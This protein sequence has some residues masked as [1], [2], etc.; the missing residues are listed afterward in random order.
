MARKKNVVTYRDEV[1]TLMRDLEFVDYPP[2]STFRVW[3]GDVPDYFGTHWHSAVEI[4]IP[5]EGSCTV[6]YDKAQYHVKAGEVL[7]TPSGEKHDLK[8]SPH[9]K[10]YIFL[11]EMES[12][13][14]IR[15][16]SAIKSMM[17]LPIH[18]TEDSP[19][20]SQVRDLLM[21]VIREYSS[22][23]PLRE[24]SCYAYILM[25]YALIGRD[26]LASAY[27]QANIQSG[28]HPAYLSVFHHVLYYIDHHFMED[29]SLESVAAEAGF[30]KYHFSRLFK[31]YTNVTFW[32]FLSLKRIQKAEQLL[33]STNRSIA[34]IAL[35]AGFDSIP[36]F[37]RIYRKIRSYTPSEYRAK[38]RRGLVS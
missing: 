4:V 19:V 8:T 35:Q 5:I 21:S 29:I 33:A 17:M 37:N 36:S 18:I 11:F 38:C 22:G 27:A 15:D 24:L 16:F 10:R 1:R 34:E 20:C 25:L 30:S 28:S 3:F 6:N 26:E 23:Q 2:N 13:L 7:I 32:H 31:Q 9:T 12:L 14:S